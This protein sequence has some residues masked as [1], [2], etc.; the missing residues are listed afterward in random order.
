MQPHFLSLNP[1]FYA[2]PRSRSSK[3]LDPRPV[4][5]P[6]VR[7]PSRPLAK[8]GLRALWLSAVLLFAPLVNAAELTLMLLDPGHFHAA[9]L[10]KEMLPGISPRAHIYAPL[11]PELMRHLQW[12]NAFNQRAENPTRWELEIHAT[13][14]SLE[15][16]LRERPG[17]IVFLS[18][19]NR[20]KIQAIEAC[21]HAG[22]HVLADKPWVIEPEDYGRLR[23]ALEI[24]RRRNVVIFD[25]MTQRYEITCLVQRELVRD[26]AILG[27]RI[28]GTEENPAVRLESVHYLLKQMAG[29]LTLR[30]TW[31]FDIHQQGEGLTDAGTH[32]VDQA[33]WT[34]FPDR[35]LEIGRDVRVVRAARWPTP[36]TR[37][38]FQQVTGAAAFPPELEPYVNGDRLDYFC[39]NRVLYTARD[40]HIQIE[41]R[42]DFAPSAGGR[43]TE[44]AVFRGSLATVERRQGPEQN[45]KSEIYVVPLQ[46]ER[47]AQVRD[48]VHKR[49]EALAARWP[50]LQAREQEGRIWVEIPDALR[51]DH[52]AHF[53]QL[54]RHFL[55][56]VSS[57]A[58]LP[59]WEKP[60]MLVKYFV[61]TRGVE[62]ARRQ[63]AASP[64]P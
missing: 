46:P 20:N 37:E 41:T 51:T 63:P 25:A 60:N 23:T 53:A 19:R 39:N 30:P 44:L 31:F 2:R 28:R 11:G 59:V 15:R 36:L 54:V 1:G 61:T 35:A 52:E 47:F 42:W 33:Q 4:L 50:G 27:E 32:L 17:S 12:V 16:L 55:G 45:F 34:F 9:L 38:Q 14:N 43:D 6:H 3:R 26:P 24:A 22:L 48:A 64:A 5:R 10:Q 57:P 62:L 49:L 7:S 40:I 58:T 29:M 56:Y 8:A 13:P 21:T 18:G